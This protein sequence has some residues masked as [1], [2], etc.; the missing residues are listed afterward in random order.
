MSTPLCG[1]PWCRPEARLVSTRLP[2]CYSERGFCG[3]GICGFPAWLKAAS[4]RQACQLWGAGPEGIGGV[5]NPKAA[6]DAQNT[7]RM[8]RT[9]AY[10]DPCPFQ[11]ILSNQRGQ[12]PL[13][14]EL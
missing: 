10:Q 2:V 4:G 3:A 9:E 11:N 6:Q 12:V 8:W 13:G 5:E 14:G 7:W 1:R